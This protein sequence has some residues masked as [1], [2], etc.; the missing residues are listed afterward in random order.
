MRVILIF[1]AIGV[2]AEV[3]AQSDTLKFWNGEFIV[4]KGDVIVHP[5]TLDGME[6]GAHYPG[7]K[8][9]MYDYLLKNLRVPQALR[10]AKQE[11]TVKVIFT[12]GKDGLP[13]NIVLSGDTTMGCGKEALRLIR[14][15][16]RWHPSAQSARVVPMRLALDVA[17]KTEEELNK[18]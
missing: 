9:A 16:P 14:E 5:P 15:M 10:E 12:I 3:C 18:K 1:L 8:E 6:V 13:K 2:R 4:L 11:R 7:G 17:F